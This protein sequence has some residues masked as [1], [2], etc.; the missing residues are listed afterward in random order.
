MIKIIHIFFNFS[1]LTQEHYADFAIMLS[2]CDDVISAEIPVY[3]EKI[4]AVIRESFDGDM[5]CLLNDSEGVEFIKKH[6]PTN[7]IFEEFL[8]KHG[9]RS[10]NEVNILFILLFFVA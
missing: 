2:S 8:I 3:I 10:L 9:H 4:A 1:E 6:K 5:F 7:E